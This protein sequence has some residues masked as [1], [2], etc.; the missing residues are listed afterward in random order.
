MAQVS[1][2]ALK[3]L[4]EEEK[5]KKVDAEVKAAKAGKAQQRKYI[6][7]TIENFRRTNRGQKLVQQELL[8]LL[9]FQARN[10]PLKPMMSM[11]KDKIR[12]TEE[13]QNFEVSVEEIMG[14]I[15]QFFSFYFREIRKKES[16]GVKVQGW[17]NEA[18]C[19]GS[20]NF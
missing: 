10:F 20:D 15:H 7:P 8:A 19:I 13:G 5:T 6:E 3:Y 4:V 18:T 17:L 11:N 9:N 16:Y 2:K 14:K 12:F 1:M